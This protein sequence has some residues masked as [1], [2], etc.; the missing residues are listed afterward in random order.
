MDMQQEV[1]MADYEF[2][3]PSVVID[4]KSLDREDNADHWFDQIAEPESKTMDLHTTPFKAKGEAKTDVPK[5]FVLPMVHD[6]NRGTECGAEGEKPSAPAVSSNLVTSWSHWPSTDNQPQRK[7]LP[8]QPRRV[9]KRLSGHQK[10]ENQRKQMAKI[11]EE[12]RRSAAATVPH[13]GD[14]PVKK[15]RKRNLNLPQ[16]S[17]A[18]V[19]HRIK[20]SANHTTREETI[21]ET[22]RWANESQTKGRLRSTTP[23]V[24]KRSNSSAK[25]KSTEQ[26]ELEKIHSLQK[27]VAEQRKKNETTFKAA[28]AGSQPAKKTVIPHTVPVDFHFRTDDRIKPHGDHQSDTSYKEVDFAAQLRKHPP[29]PAKV[30]KGHTIPKPFNLS[31]GTKRK[32]EETAYVP[33]AQQIEQFQKRTPARYHLRSR[34]KEEKGPS[35]VKNI[36]LK[37]TDPKTPQ[38]LTRKRT[39]P[40]FVKSTAEIEAEEIEQIHQFKFKALELNRKVLDGA[41]VPKKPPVKESTQPIGFDLEIEKRLQEREASKKPEAQDEYTFHSRPLPVKILEDVV[42][43][44]EKKHLPPTVPQSPA[45]ALKNRVRI[46]TRKEEE[47]ECPVIKAHPMPH[48]GL[49]F[50]PKPL[51]NKHVEVCP[52]SF[53]ARER[54]RL[55]LKEKKLEELRHEEVPNFKAQPLP[56]FSE[57]HLPEKKVAEATKVQ[58]FKL[59]IDERGAKKTEHWEQALKEELRQQAEAASFRARPNTVT[60]KEPFVPKKENRP[61]TEALSNSVVTEGF[62]LST[63][64][65][66]KERMEFDHIVAEKERQRALKE[67]EERREQEEKAKEEISRLR[68]EQVHKAQPVRRYK[69]LELKK[70]EVSLTVPQSPNFSDR[71]RV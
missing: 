20:R 3:A 14:P 54:E 46:E 49:P 11:R 55:A 28:I 52:F 33:M 21:S 5:A 66:A 19:P 16:L 61:T 45:F 47:K 12:K 43:V 29:S 48:F 70:S 64:R 6:A 44:P 59:L 58:P 36:K 23:T 32:F 42:G 71:F 40:L 69:P 26:Q 17:R 65:R 62:Q 18:N 27:E 24:L 39:R 37:I 1:S 34:Q 25:F 50:Q 41:L 63:E 7:A 8:A 53:D 67:E 4:F 15:L 31:S 56:D 68:Q 57:V 38:L 35:P 22:T 9:S 2:D 60:H 10:M 30:S 51:E 13:A